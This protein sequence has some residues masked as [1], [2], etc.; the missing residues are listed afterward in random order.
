MARASSV[1]VQGYEDL[2]R[3]IN[4]IGGDT[5]K[6]VKE[7]L[8]KVG[9]STRA[10]AAERASRKGFS[11]RTVTGYRVVVRQRGIAVEQARRKTTG[12]QTKFG[13]VQ[14]RKALLPAR[15]ASV[16]QAQAEMERA[17]ERIV[18]RFGG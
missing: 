7:E 4:Y 17:L 3:T 15:D 6:A 16:E 13:S 1:R 9:E 10:G 12:K 11:A 8:R 18:R 5:K 2:I 14:M